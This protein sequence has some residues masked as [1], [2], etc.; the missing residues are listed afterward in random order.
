[1]FGALRRGLLME[2]FAQGEPA[3]HAGVAEQHDRVAEA[4]H[5]HR[6]AKGG[7]VQVAQ[8]L[9]S[10]ARVAFEGLLQA[11]DVLALVD[12]R[13]QLDD[14][15]LVGG[16]VRL[17]GAGCGLVGAVHRPADHGGGAG[18]EA[19]FD[20]RGA[21]HARMHDGDSGAG[22]LA[23]FQHDLFEHRGD[24]GGQRRLG[25][26]LEH[27]A[28]AGG[29][30]RGQRGGMGRV[31]GDEGRHLDLG[32]LGR[33][34]ADQCGQQRFALR[35]EQLAAAGPDRRQRAQQLGMVD[36]RVGAQRNQREPRARDGVLTVDDRC[37]AQGDTGQQGLVECGGG[38]V[39][40][41]RRTRVE[42]AEAAAK[43]S[44]CHEHT[45]AHASKRDFALEGR[46]CAHP[47]TRAA[48]I[49]R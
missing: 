7:G 27:T 9:E 45:A 15:L 28:V 48:A 18:L 26:A 2:E 31:S 37:I 30:E 41:G 14:D 36:R 29:L 17:G 35:V 10:Q 24:L 32:G 16:D 20:G 44:V 46:R 43:A 33:R 13:H 12:A 40:H 4:R 19:R 49:R 25:L 47:A 11:L 6:Q 42:A 38:G 3:L 1:M 39:G 5:L 21:T 8:Q 22:G 23:G 34:L